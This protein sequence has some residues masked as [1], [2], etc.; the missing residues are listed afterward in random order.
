MSS[1]LVVEKIGSEEALRKGAAPDDIVFVEQFRN[2]G[3]RCEVLAWRAVVRRELGANV[4]ISHDEFG[5]PTTENPKRYISVSH[6]KESVAVLLS[7]A[8]CAVDIEQC[9]RNFRGVASH[10]LLPQELA[11]AE[12]YDLFAEMWCAKE[13]LYKF[14]RKGGMDFARDIVIR[15]YHASENILLATILDSEPIRVD[16]S[17]DN[18]LVIALVGVNE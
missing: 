18:D 12:E 14:Y 13:A 9:A 16:I 15:E 11:M 4:V 8:P 17:R 1:R 3:R 6:S 10:Y 5:A 7:D 2:A